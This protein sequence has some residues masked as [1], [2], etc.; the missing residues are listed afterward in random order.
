MRPIALLVLAAS[1]NAAAAQTP[2][3]TPPPPACTA[4]EHRQF[5]FWLGHWDV[6][7]TGTSQLVGHNLIEKLYDGCTIR[8][9][10]MPLRGPGGS[11]FNTYRVDEKAWRQTWVDGSNSHA[12]FKGGLEGGSMVIAGR[13]QGVNGPGTDGFV[14]ITYT[15]LPDG[16]L[17]QVGVISTD[18][19]KSFQP[20]FDLTYRPSP[21]AGARSA[22]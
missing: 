11:S 22:H 19:R 21:K 1:L 2:P 20:S 17:R 13:W 16:S 8:E 3:Q 9:S 18:G 10:W 14:R 6:Y 15:R 4:P 7:R 12:D 5:D